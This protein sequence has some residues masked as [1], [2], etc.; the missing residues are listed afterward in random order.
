MR[1]AMSVVVFAGMIGVTLYRIFLTPVFYVL[2]RFLSGSCALKL[3][4]GVPVYRA[5]SRCR[6]GSG[7]EAGPTSRRSELGYGLD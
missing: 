2:P 3:N 7:R 1:H 4:A 5:G 6:A